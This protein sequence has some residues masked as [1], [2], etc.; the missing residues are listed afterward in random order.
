MFFVTSAHPAIQRNCGEPDCHC[1]GLTGTLLHRRLAPP[2]PRHTSATIGKVNMQ[3]HDVGNIPKKTPFVKKLLGDRLDTTSR[4]GIILLC[5]PASDCPTATSGCTTWLAVL[6]GARSSRLF[7]AI[8]CRHY[9]NRLLLR[10]ITPALTDASAW[11]QRRLNR[12]HS[13]LLTS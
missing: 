3:N 8:M 5:R 4:L 11:Q 9:T 2:S 12:L 10:G 13:V 7:L 1:S 6:D